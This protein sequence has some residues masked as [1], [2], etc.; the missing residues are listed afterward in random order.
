M[1][2][3]KVN[4]FIIANKDKLPD[5]KIVYIKDEM[6]KASDSK[7]NTIISLSLKNPIVGLILSLFLGYLGIDRFYAGDALKGIL[8]LITLGGCGIW[9]IIDWILIMDA[10]KEKNFSEIMLNLK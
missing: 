7:F 4:S 2:E 9:V 3:N 8:K 6:I 5:A 1:E 10:I